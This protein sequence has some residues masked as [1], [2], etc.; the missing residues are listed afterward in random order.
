MARK[1]DTPCSGCGKLLW[2]GKHSL[3]F[4]ERMCR[5]CRA[6]RPKRRST[7]RIVNC[8]ASRFQEGYCWQHLKQA[9]LE[10]GDLCDVTGCEAPRHT[11]T[12]CAKHYSANY[13]RTNPR[14]RDSERKPRD[15]AVCGTTF[16]ATNRNTR[17]CSDRCKGWHYSYLKR[18]PLLPVLHPNPSPA[19]PLPRHHPAR[20]PATSPTRWWRIIVVGPCGWCGSD[21][22]GMGT[23]VDGA[24]RYCSRRCSS[25]AGKYRRGAFLVPPA[26]RQAIYE[27]DDRTCQLCGDPVDLTLGA[28]DPW[29]P[30]LDHII[31]RSWT[32]TP[33]DS[34]GNLRLAHRWCNSVRGDE[35]YY[36]ADDLV[37]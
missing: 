27:R 23:H 22:T 6:Q 7:C 15:C 13:R 29:G 25:A 18:A 33:D 14:A 5:E 10:R 31:C 20:R 8:E 19:S 11:S 37:A 16:S 30:T 9:R 34:P 36:T 28:A 17:F 12:V 2:T 3:P 1:P 35:R 4:A 21:F 32:D 24:P 26:V